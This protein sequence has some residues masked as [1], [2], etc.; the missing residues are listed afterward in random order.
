MDE[1]KRKSGFV[2]NKHTG[3]LYGFVDLGNV[4]RYIEMAVSGENKESPASELV[5][6]AFVFLARP[7]FKPSLSVP[8]AHYFSANL[9]GMIRVNVSF[10]LHTVH[11]REDISSGVGS[12]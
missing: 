7:V 1:M 2:F 3:I 10:S 11:R 8:A 4:N 5:E 9:T 12:C 6:Q